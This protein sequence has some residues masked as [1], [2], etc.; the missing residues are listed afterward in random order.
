MVGPHERQATT[1]Q[2][3]FL[4]AL[5]CEQVAAPPDLAGGI[6]PHGRIESFDAHVV[7]LKDVVPQMACKHAISTVLPARAVDC[8]APSTEAPLQ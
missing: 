4:N 7:L 1:P 5:R 3:T 8:P 6:R 2:D